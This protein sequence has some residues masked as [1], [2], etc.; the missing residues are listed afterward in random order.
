MRD[1]KYRRATALEFVR[2]NYTIGDWLLNIIIVLTLL[3]LFGAGI[4]RGGRWA[5][6]AAYDAWVY[7][8]DK[9]V[10]RVAANSMAHFMRG[11]E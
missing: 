5:V 7:D 9:R 10:E 6:N 2:A 3:V 1:Y 8:Q 11:D 4:A